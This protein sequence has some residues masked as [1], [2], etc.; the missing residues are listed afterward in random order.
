MTRFQYPLLFSRP[1]A[2]KG[3]PNGNAVKPPSAAARITG[4]HKSAKSACCALEDMMATRHYTRQAFGLNKRR[5][6]R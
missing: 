4:K 1:S 6:V 5:E 3:L 2:P